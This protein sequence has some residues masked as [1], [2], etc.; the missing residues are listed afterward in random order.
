[1][2]CAKRMCGCLLFCRIFS[3]AL[4]ESQ[5][6]DVNAL[7]FY[8]KRDYGTTFFRCCSRL[9]TLEI[10]GYKT[11]ALRSNARG[12]TYNTALYLAEPENPWTLGVH[13]RSEA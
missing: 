11:S 13:K 9:K 1:M 2:Q 6:Y 7:Y 5:N 3:V 12:K 8:W 4:I 10:S